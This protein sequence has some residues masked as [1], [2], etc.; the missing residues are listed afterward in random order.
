MAETTQAEA[1]APEKEKGKGKGKGKGKK[2]GWKLGSALLV[3]VLAALGV[4]SW[5]TQPGGAENGG[6]EA[7]PVKST[8]HL[9]PFVVN[10]ADRDQGSYLRVGVD[11]GLNRELRH[12]EEMPVAQVRDVILSILDNQKADDLLTAEGKSK[13]KSALLQAL[14][15][16][17]PELGVEEVYFTELL[18]QR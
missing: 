17:V 9:E 1:I 3:I 10:L 14:K 15:E 18:I 13:L 4:W 7:R 5:S 16:Q 12:G 8:L 11:L 2:N 6:T